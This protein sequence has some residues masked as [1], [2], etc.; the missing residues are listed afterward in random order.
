MME[1]LTQEN[2][3]TDIGVK[4]E[5]IILIRTVFCGISIF[6]C[7][8]LILVYFILCFQVK[9]NI[10]SK[11]KGEEDRKSLL[12]NE[13]LNENNEN[14]NI[15]KKKKI[16]L[17]SNFMFI[18]TVSNFLGSLFEFFFYFYFVNKRKEIFKEGKKNIN[19]LYNE[20]NDKY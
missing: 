1:L 5:K 13:S 15:N 20:I 7:F 3:I 11:N 6:C 16:G 18:I 12:E 14:M 17:G 19:D 10:C 2:N 8:G 9:F 4:E